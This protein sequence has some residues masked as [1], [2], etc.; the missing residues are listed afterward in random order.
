MRIL[1]MCD[2]YDH[3]FK[4]LLLGDASSGKTS[5]LT[6]IVHCIF[7]DSMHSIGVD[8]AIKTIEFEG[9]ALKFQIWDTAGQERFRTITAAYFRG[10]NAVLFVYDIANKR[11]FENIPTY[12]ASALEHNPDI[13]G[14]IVGNK[15]DLGRE[16]EVEVEQLEELADRHNMPFLEVCTKTGAN[17]DALLPLA[18]ARIL[19]RVDPDD[20]D[21]RPRTLSPVLDQPRV[22]SRC[23]C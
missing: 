1:R 12:I 21:T 13:V 11:T 20:R 8:F 19:A 4:V 2:N 16:R 9:K 15:T 5:L 10:A 17:T 22:M 6:R 3:L 7:N 14:I 23:G 18:A